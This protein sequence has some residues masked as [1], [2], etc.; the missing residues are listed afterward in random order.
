MHPMH[1]VAS[2]GGPDWVASQAGRGVVW[3]SAGRVDLVIRAVQQHK[4]VVVMTDTESRL[5]RPMCDLLQSVAGRWAVRAA[6]QTWYDG[7]TGAALPDLADPFA[8]HTPRRISDWFARPV[9]PD[10]LHLLVSWSIRHRAELATVIGTSVE[11]FLGGL[12]LGWPTGWGLHEPTTRAWDPADLTAYLRGRSPQASR[13][14]ITADGP[15]PAVLVL[16]LK[17]TDHG[18]QEMVDGVINVGPWPDPA[19]RERV[20]RVP[21]VL[22]SLCET[23][24]PLAGWALARPGEPDLAV[25]PYLPPPPM[26]VAWLIGPPTAHALDLDLIRMESRFQA[27]RVGRAAMPGLVYPLVPHSQADHTKLRDIYQDIGVDKIKSL[28]G[29]RGAAGPG[30]A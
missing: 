4:R 28:V 9:I 24:M 1:P 2:F 7:L 30:G 27:R 22:G 19:T 18:L 10:A 16:R 11:T 14:V 3:M 26:P 17:R 21:Q 12:D 29:Y 15:N 8:D 6:D 5:T 20:E 25:P 23:M 13:V